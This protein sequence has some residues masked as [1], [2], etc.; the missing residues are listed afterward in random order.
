MR[1]REK[2]VPWEEIAKTVGLSERQAHSVHEQF[3]KSEGRQRDHAAV[4]DETI[5]TFTVAMQEA[6]LTYEAAE[7]GSSVRVQALRAAM[8]AALVRFQIMRAAG[9]AP[10]SLA[11]PGVAAQLQEAFRE[12]ASLLAKHGVKDEVLRDF[13]LLAES[14]IGAG[15]Q[16]IEGRESLSA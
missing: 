16:V 4:V 15:G 9:R 12:F 7:L 2:P 13:L 10:R 14:K 1:A 11:G 8:D 6:W 5:A 3:L